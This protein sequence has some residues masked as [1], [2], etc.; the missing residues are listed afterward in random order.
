MLM[1]SE[2]AMTYG[3]SRLLSMMIALEWRSLLVVGWMVGE[4]VNLVSLMAGLRA[5][6]GV[7]PNARPL[8][9]PQEVICPYFCL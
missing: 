4:P 3:P 7:E 5:D 9:R 6:A 2:Q 8:G 1:I